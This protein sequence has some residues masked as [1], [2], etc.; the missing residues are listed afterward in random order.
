MTIIYNFIPH[1][2]MKVQIAAVLLS[3]QI[4]LADCNSNVGTREKRLEF[5][6]LDRLVGKTFSLRW[7]ILQQDRTFTE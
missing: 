5:L 2:L 4:L 1:V 6:C 3:S 7:I